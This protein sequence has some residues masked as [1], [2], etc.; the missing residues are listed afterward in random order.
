[1]QGDECGREKVHKGRCNEHACTE[2]PREEEESVRDGQ[3][4]EAADDDWERAS[5]R[6]QI[7]FV[8]FSELECLP[9]KCT[10]SQYYEQRSNV[11]GSIVAML[12]RVGAAGWSQ[13]VSLR[14]TARELCPEQFSGYIVPL[15]RICKGCVSTRVS[16]RG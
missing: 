6:A 8:W 2:V 9:T 14:L 7:S 5:C 16:Q 13:L 1:M 11:S 10:Q 15:R 12:R 4:R 3:A